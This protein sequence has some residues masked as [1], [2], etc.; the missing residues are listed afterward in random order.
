MV[1]KLHADLHP[2]CMLYNCVICANKRADGRVSMYYVHGLQEVRWSVTSR[3]VTD[4][5]TVI[6]V[7]ATAVMKDTTSARLPSARVRCFHLT[8]LP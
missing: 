6:Q 5:V 7:S 2:V 3:T 1:V 8:S 4:V